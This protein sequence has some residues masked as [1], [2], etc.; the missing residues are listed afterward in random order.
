MPGQV[1][2]RRGHAAWAAA[3]ALAFTLP[4]AMSALRGGDVTPAAA[5]SI[6][7]PPAV[8]HV[9]ALRALRHVAALPAPPAAPR[10]H[11][12]R[13]AT[14][15]RPATHAPVTVAAPAPAPARVPAR[16]PA[17]P[18]KSFDSSG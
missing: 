17:A 8:G 5:A 6:A 2:L 10:R 4:F 1:S 18:R 3:I 11:K 12:P 9:P 7:R 15:P 13:A 16:A 14:T